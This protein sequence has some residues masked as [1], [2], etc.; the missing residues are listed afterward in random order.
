MLERNEFVVKR[1]PPKKYDLEL[2]TWL[3]N[4]TGNADKKI[5]DKRENGKTKKKRWKMLTQTRKSNTRK[6]DNTIRE[7]KSESSGERRK[8]KKDI[9]T[10]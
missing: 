9:K 7:N 4:S 3:G 1:S 5:K 6:N 2:K 8:I 10:G